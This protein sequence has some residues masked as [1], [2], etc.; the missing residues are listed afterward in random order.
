M[1]ADKLSIVNY[2]KE[3]KSEL[4]KDGISKI[5]LFGSFARNEQSVYSDIDIAIQKENNYLVQRSAY[6]Y[7]EEVSKIKNLIR[8][9]FHRNSDIFD[10]DSNSNMKKSISKDLIYV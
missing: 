1:K 7:F 8:K 9:K 2:L 6:D 3:I 5:A 10:L 4:E